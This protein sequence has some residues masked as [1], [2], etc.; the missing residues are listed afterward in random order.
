M[1]PTVCCERLQVQHEV[2]AL[3]APRRNHATEL[4][5][6]RRRQRVVAVLRGEFIIVGGRRPPSR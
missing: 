5:L 1:T 4:T 6:V 2:V 3:G